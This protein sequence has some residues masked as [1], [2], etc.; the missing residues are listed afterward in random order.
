MRPREGNEACERLDCAIGSVPFTM[1]KI[2]PSR[3]KSSIQ[4]INQYFAPLPVRMAIRYSK[5]EPV[6]W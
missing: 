2:P 3:A 6:L 1:E 5:F 4:T